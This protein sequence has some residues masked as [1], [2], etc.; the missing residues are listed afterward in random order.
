MRLSD[1]KDNLI[2]T[3][4]IGLHNISYKTEKL[5]YMIKQTVAIIGGDKRQLYAAK[6]L[7]N[8]NC[9]VYMVG[10]E[11][12]EHCEGLIITDFDEALK[13]ADYFLFPVTGVKGLVVPTAYSKNPIKLDDNLLEQLKSKRIFCGKADTLQSLGSELRI[14]DYL[15]REEFA[16]ANALP[17]AEGAVQ[18]AMEQYEG[19]LFNSD[20]LVIGYGR[21]GKIL[22]RML[23]ALNAN[24]TVSARKS[25]HLRYIQ[26]DGNTSIKTDEINS[27]DEFDIVF[28][29]VP[30]LVIDKKILAKTNP[31]TLI[32][33]LASM[34]G[35][36]DFLTA[37]KFG[38]K[39]IH[40]L[41][42]PGKCAPKAAGEIISD[43]V[44][45]M[46]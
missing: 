37:E 4:G 2:C 39:V 35:G 8:N 5:F 18:I 34:P 11:K 17:T 15:R 3:F 22:S 20:C 40:A 29:T 36:V 19:T 44:L 25:D 33:D 21:I 46:F 10:F 43:T 31:E 38:I 42:L 9:K 32:I 7:Q 1:K 41:S 27:L 6:K 26:S 14:C 45:D 23:R 12:L 28:N 16:V 13:K 30:K 24:V